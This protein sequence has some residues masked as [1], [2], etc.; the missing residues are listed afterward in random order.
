MCG[1]AIVT[2]FQFFLTGKTTFLVTRALLGFMQGGFIPDLVLYL[3]CEIHVSLDSSRSNWA[4]R[5][6]HQE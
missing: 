1:W 3:S 6:L 5:L 2:M 4:R